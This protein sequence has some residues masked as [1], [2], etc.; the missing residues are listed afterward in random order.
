MPAGVRKTAGE[1]TG[2]VPLFRAE[3]RTDYAEYERFNLFV[4]KH[5]RSRLLKAV[6]FVL[7]IGLCIILVETFLLQQYVATL[8]LASFL[9][10]YIWD[11]VTQ[12]SVKKHFRRMYESNK[13][14][15]NVT[16]KYSFYEDHFE[17]A[18]LECSDSIAY[19]KPDEM[20]E[21]ETNSCL[22]IARNQ[23]M[24][25]SKASCSAGLQDFY[26]NLRCC[27]GLQPSRQTETG[28]YRSA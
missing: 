28:K 16:A 4:M 21:S 12:H 3:S 18:T 8:I 11:K 22:M 25:L 14:I 19:D 23:G 7:G 2:A 15:Q 13:F 27:A 5:N 24:V 1:A 17:S 26:E 9:A 20:L 10:W 6:P